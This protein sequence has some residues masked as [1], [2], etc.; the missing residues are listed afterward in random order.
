[1]RGVGE[2]RHRWP[3]AMAFVLVGLLLAGWETFRGK[4]ARLSTVPEEVTNARDSLPPLRQDMTWQLPTVIEY[5]FE[6]NTS[7]VEC[8]SLTRNLPNLRPR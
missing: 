5:F 1:M 6:T 3:V 7:P 2:L 8:T 4:P